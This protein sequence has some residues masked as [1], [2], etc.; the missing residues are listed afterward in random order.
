M[1]EPM[2]RQV[3]LDCLDGDCGRGLDSDRSIRPIELDDYVL[4]VLMDLH[5]F[6]SWAKPARRACESIV[7]TVIFEHTL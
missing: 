3:V 2:R 4:A 1:V 7:V 6:C 5:A